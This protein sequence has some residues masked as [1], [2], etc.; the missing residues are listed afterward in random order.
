MSERRNS[1]VIDCVVSAVVAAITTLFL[2]WLG[3]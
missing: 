3:M 1:I 2:K